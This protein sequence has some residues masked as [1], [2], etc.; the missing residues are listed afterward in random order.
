ML[1][2]C[3][4]LGQIHIPYLSHTRR[5]IVTRIILVGEWLY[6]PAV[7]WEVSQPPSGAGTSNAKYATCLS[8]LCQICLLFVTS[9]DKFDKCLSQTMANIP[10]FFNKLC[11]IVSGRILVGEWLHQPAVWWEVLQPP[12]GAGGLGREKGPRQLCHLQVHHC[13]G[14][15]GGQHG[16]INQSRAKNKWSVTVTVSD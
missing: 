2:L 13:V 4:K 6:Q 15:R 10:I 5:I 14:L 1:N 11:L 8:R 9:S 16:T 12:G 7:W 3:H